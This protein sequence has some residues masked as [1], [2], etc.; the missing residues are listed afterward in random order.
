MNA[1]TGEGKTYDT[2]PPFWFRRSGV[3]LPILMLPMVFGAT[4]RSWE[5]FAIGLA[6]TLL[7]GAFVLGW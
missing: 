6:L 4:L 1:W 3:V 5:A 2:E 7:F